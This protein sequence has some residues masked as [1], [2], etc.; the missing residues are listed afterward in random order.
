MGGQLGE[1]GEGGGVEV[2]ELG[3]GGGMRKEA[4]EA[5]GVAGCEE[6]V[7]LD[8]CEKVGYGFH[9]GVRRADNDGETELSMMM[10]R[11]NEDGSVRAYISRSPSNSLNDPRPQS[12]LRQ[13][14][15]C[16]KIKYPLSPSSGLSI[17]SR[18]AHNPVKLFQW[19]AL[20]FM[21]LREA[22]QL[23]TPVPYSM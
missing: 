18:V 14:K 1:L 23:C 3:S 16:N 21:S 10:M 6:A 22:D 11:L 5:G 19:N 15:K 20:L 4:G 2:E 9:G 17:S 12:C 13:C 7:R 8:C